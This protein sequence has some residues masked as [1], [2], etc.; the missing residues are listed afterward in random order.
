LAKELEERYLEWLERMEIPIEETTTI[1]RWRE[2]LSRQIEVTPERLAKSWTAIETWW[3][4]M[5]EKG[6]MPR[7]IEYPWGR[8]L[9]FAI[10]GRRG[11]FG[12]KRMREIIRM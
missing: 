3:L 9:R 1:E 11:W 12:L 5:K 6:V 10:K 8:A 7:I 4:P 2:W